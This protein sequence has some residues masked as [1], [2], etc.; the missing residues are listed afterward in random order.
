MNWGIVA[1]IVLIWVPVGSFAFWWNEVRY[2]KKRGMKRPNCNSDMISFTK[3]EQNLLYMFWPITLVVFALF[4]LV[5]W[6]CLAVEW[7]V[8]FFA[9]K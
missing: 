1:L 7:C 4:V 3:K 2:Y 6:T 5:G 9:K 8:D